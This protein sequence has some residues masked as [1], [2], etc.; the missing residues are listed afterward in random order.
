MV[1][2]DTFMSFAISF[3]FKKAV[4]LKP[5]YAF[6]YNNLGAVYMKKGEFDSA[7]KNFEK[8]VQINPGYNQAWANLGSAKEMK[9]DIDGAVQAWEKAVA[10]G[11]KD[12]QSF[13]NYY[14]R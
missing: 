11:A 9:R 4:S 1:A 14:K 5:D 6:A 3:P 7:I 12:A 8:A 2:S 13:I 10:A